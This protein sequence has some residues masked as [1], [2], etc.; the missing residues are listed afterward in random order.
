M[1]I[2]IV[3]ISFNQVRFLQRAIESVLNQSGC[4]LE[5]IVVDPGSTDGSRDIIERY[6]G[7]IAKIILEPD[8][9]PPDGLNKGFASATGQIG[10]YLN[11]DDEFLPGALADVVVSFQ[12][13]PSSDVIYGDGYIVDESGRI[14]RE[15]LSTPFSARAYVYGRTWVM[16]QA[17][18]FRL[19]AFRKTGG[20]R[21]ESKTA[22]DGDLLVDFA[23]SGA[24]L[25]HVP[26]RW[27][28]FRIYPDSITGSNR[29]RREFKTDQQ[30][31]FQRVMLRDPFWYDSALEEAARL[32]RLASHPRRTATRALQK[33]REFRGSHRL[34]PNHASPSV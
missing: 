34:P 28:L 29:L 8:Q 6:K 17:T 7:H 21:M 15:F 4:D 24:R 26:R 5:Y 23:L 14:T 2:S 32:I 13:N 20:F 33:Y 30:R 16:Q 3:T 18:F 25:V 10:G 11:A 12:S 1:K 9:G 31:I 22:W 19:N 27:G